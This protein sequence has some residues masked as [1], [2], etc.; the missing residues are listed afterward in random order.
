MKIIIDGNHIEKLTDT[1]TAVQA[2]CT[3]RT[4]TAADVE[5]ILQKATESLRGISKAAMKGVKV[6]YT[7]GERFPNAY[8]Y[9]PE[10]TQFAAEHNGKHWVIYE[11]C[12]A[13]CP[14]RL[15]NV[16]FILT[17][18]AQAAILQT[19]NLMHV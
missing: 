11:L 19:Y 8:R 1:L 5:H 9:R 12:R 18:T 13:E 2:R 3:A 15:D 10:S 16:G 4:L 17:E 6:I 7:G 14:N